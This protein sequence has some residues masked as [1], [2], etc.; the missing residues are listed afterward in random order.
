MWILF[1]LI[2]ACFWAVVNI[3][4]KLTLTKLVKKPI[5][6]T[7]LLSFIDVVIALIILLN[8][9]VLISEQQIILFLIASIGG[10]G[11]T[12]LY[13][14]AI[15]KEETSRVVPLFS[16]SLIWIMIIAAIFLD[17]VFGFRE[18]L[19]ILLIFLGSVL[20]S[21][22]KK[23]NF[24]IGGSLFLM[25]GSTILFA[26]YNVAEKYLLEELNFWSVFAYTGIF[27]FILLIP[28]ILFYRKELL[29]TV[30]EIRFKG[31]G[32]LMSITILD[33]FGVIFFLVALSSGYVTLVEAV[34]SMQ[35]VFVFLLTIFLSLFLPKI[36]KE[37][38]NKPIVILKLTA[39]ILI[40]GGVVLIT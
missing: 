9:F 36:F 1:S 22:K 16:L 8:N 30:R 13:F 25:I 14:Q 17:E 23:I 27:V 26:I 19:G 10:I 35:Y 37:K 7:I 34:V 33:S 2:A 28:A 39:I 40:T 31:I 20:I 12:I 21:L 6:A 4:D 38:I 24:Q 32:A 29:K 11:G 3:I 15:R 18:Y 5:I